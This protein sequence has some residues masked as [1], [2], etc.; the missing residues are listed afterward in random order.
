MSEY[1][2]VKFTV[3]GTP[4]AKGR[5]KFAR[6]GKFT[7]AYTPK[8]TVNYETLVKFAFIQHVGADFKPFDCPLILR[9]NAYF[10]RPKSH[11]RTGKNAGILKDSA[12]QHMTNKPDWDNIGKITD[13]LN[14]VAFTDDKLI[15]TGI[16]SK[17]YSDR[18][19]CEVEIDPIAT[20]HSG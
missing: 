8:K 1:Q 2:G 12:P 9:V 18:P 3:Q 11:Y 16:V 6:R 20:P 4:V 19:R 13:A 5:P 10:P 14:E 7:V 17:H 15:V